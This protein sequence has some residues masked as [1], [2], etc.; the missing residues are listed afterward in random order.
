MLND[1]AAV[2]GDLLRAV[3]QEVVSLEIGP[4]LIDCLFRYISLR[5]QLLGLTLVF[6]NAQPHVGRVLQPL[7]QRLLGGEVELPQ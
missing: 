1:V 2:P 5:Q 3:T 4:E 7:A 6:A